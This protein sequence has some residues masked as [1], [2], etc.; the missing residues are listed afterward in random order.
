MAT[1]KALL[2]GALLGSAAGANCDA[3]DH[4][5]D[6]AALCELQGTVKLD[7]WCNGQ[8]VCGWE[9][10]T[11]TDGRVTKLEL[12]HLVKAASGPV[13]AS[14]GK[15]SKLQALDITNCG[16]NGRLPDSIGN[17][18]ELQRVWMG[19][20][21]FTQGIP[22]AVGKLAN[23]QQFVLHYNRELGGSIP[24]SL[25]NL[26]SLNLLLLN[27]NSLTGSVPESLGSLS[28]LGGL[29]LFSNKLTAWTSDSL[30]KLI[31][32]G[33]LSDC[34]FQDNQFACPLPSC[35]AN[36]SAVCKGAL[37]V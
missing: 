34:E 16:F 15:L 29:G 26:K 4:P 36:C 1:L 22:A 3:K 33:S 37:V 9:G 25:G 27:N 31:A 30:C 6:C 20:N 7:S 12:N 13:P 35:A 10:I 24:A 11:C 5:D 19:E 28:S 8:T 18:T 17:L 2:L 32:A 14:I 21:D 23:L